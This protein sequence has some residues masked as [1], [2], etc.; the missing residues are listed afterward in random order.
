M[1]GIACGPRR[2]K[3]RSRQPRR[4][5]CRS[6]ALPRHRHVHHAAASIWARHLSASARAS[7]S[8]FAS[9]GLICSEEDDGAATDGC[10]LVAPSGAP[11]WPRAVLCVDAAVWL[12]DERTS[13][14]MEMRHIFFTAS[15]LLRG[16]RRARKPGKAGGRASWTWA[17]RSNF[18]K[19]R[20]PAIYSHEPANS[21]AIDCSF[22]VIF[23]RFRRQRRSRNAS[24]VRPARPETPCRYVPCVR[25]G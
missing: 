22:Q 19:S 1:Q 4:S 6:S 13:A 11:T 18:V 21:C 24:A 14:R 8:L 25:L 23:L 20:R 3:R 16:N 7:A 15:C 9:S 12:H 10:A 17:R 5:I 2:A